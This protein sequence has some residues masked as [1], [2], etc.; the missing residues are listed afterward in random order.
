MTQSAEA[1]AMANTLR[2]RPAPPR[3]TEEI[4]ISEHLLM[5]IAMR[6]IYLRGTCT[7][8]TLAGFM[9]LSLELAEGLFRK[10][11][12]QKFVEVHRMVGDDF[13]FALSVSGRRMSMERSET[14]RYSGPVPV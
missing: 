13:V 6:H 7:I 11:L 1:T 8:Q 12:D 9:K 5:D 14:L 2:W 10:L 3:V 4:D